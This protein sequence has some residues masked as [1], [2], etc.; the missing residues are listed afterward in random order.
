ME[1]TPDRKIAGILAP[2]FALRT[3]GISASAMW[4][5]CAS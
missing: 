3:D 2:L 4:A 5:R 1:L